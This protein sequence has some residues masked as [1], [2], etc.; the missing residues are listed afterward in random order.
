[1]Y[2]NTTTFVSPAFIVG[3]YWYILI[4]NC[5]IEIKGV[6]KYVVNVNY[7]PDASWTAGFNL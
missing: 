7:G 4:R 2:S 3:K 6:L 5:R 1:M